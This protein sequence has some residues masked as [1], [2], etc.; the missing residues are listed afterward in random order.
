M[1]PHAG[2][3]RTPKR[4]AGSARDNDG[5]L[6]AWVD[7]FLKPGT[8]AGGF[9][10]YQ[11]AHAGRVA[12][13]REQAPVLPPIGVPTCVRWAEH[14][15]LFP[16]AWTDRLG[17]TFADLDLAMFEGV[18]HFPHREDP[19]RAGAEIAGFFSRIGHH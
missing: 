11:A 2:S 13:M 6:E 18:G 15:A 1:I 16:Y 9:A 17:E 7:N 10:Y 14:D 3:R 19:E 8:L 12:I 5:V 4:A